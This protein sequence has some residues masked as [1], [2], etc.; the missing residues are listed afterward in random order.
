MVSA[1]G[2][3]DTRAEMEGN[4]GSALRAVKAKEK[5]MEQASRSGRHA[6]CSRRGKQKAGDGWQHAVLVF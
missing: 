5:Q 4:C 6:G 3:G 2:D 1:H